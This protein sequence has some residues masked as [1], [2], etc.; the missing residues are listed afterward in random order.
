MIS[1]TFFPVYVTDLLTASDLAFRN[2]WAN[3]LKNHRKL[4]QNSTGMV[5]V[6]P[7]PQVYGAY[8]PEPPSDFGKVWWGLSPYFQL[9]IYWIGISLC[10]T[11]GLPLIVNIS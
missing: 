1:G 4:A 8:A 10:T 5:L 6:K 11:V 7:A 2:T 3:H 9:N